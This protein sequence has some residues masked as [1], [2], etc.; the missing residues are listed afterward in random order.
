MIAR[1]ALFLRPGTVIALL[2]PE[3]DLTTPEAR[4]R[5]RQRRVILSAGASAIAK[6]VTIV[7]SL[8]SVPL[9][10]HYLGQER[11][12]IWVIIS[13]FTVML[14]FADMGLGNGILNAV[15]AE[16]GRGDDAAI[17]RVISSGYFMLGCVSLVITL[18]FT[19]S[20]PF[21]SW[22]RLFNVSSFAAR[23][24]AGPALASFIVFFVIAI[25]V[26]LVQKVQIGLQQGFYS[27]LWQCL[28]SIVGFL[29]LLAVIRFEG[30]LIWLVAALVG[31]PLVAGL[32]NT[33]IFF[34]GAGSKFRPAIRFIDRTAMTIAG[35]TGALFFLLQ[36][37]VAV[38]YGADNIIIAQAAG[39]ASVAQY[40]VPERM[41]AT[42]SMVISM[43]LAPL[44]PAYGE[45]IVRG[46]HDWV[47]KT[48]K[49]AVIGAICV[50]APLCGAL[51]VLGP[52]IIHLWVGPQIT[53]SLLLLC[54]LGLWKVTDAA[55]STLSVFMNGANMLIPQICIAVGC[56]G[57]MVLMK[58]FLV[59]TFG[60]AGMPWAAIITFIP[61]GAVPSAILIAR[62]LRSHAISN[63]Q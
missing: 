52:T 37:V 49:R 35:K 56:G 29:A 48:L 31:M 55:S 9:T 36:L 59:K 3:P 44:W 14:S 46:D 15:A 5:D 12:G 22:Y 62:K 43:I 11:Y 27:S 40:A 18:A 39:A 60:V 13:S 20:Y 1:A 24:E 4:G 8:I 25:P 26:G 51:V 2:R 6:L 7:A 58:I 45:A 57:A 32:I 50:S 47:R 17:R 19:I 41:F 61:L 23:A 21:F 10:L 42:V 54:G 34:F 53:P 16:H 28:G 30:G 33:I 63:D 38:A